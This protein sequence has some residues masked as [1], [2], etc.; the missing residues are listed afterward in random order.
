MLRKN[1]KKLKNAKPHNHMLN[2]KVVATQK[3]IY[4]IL[5]FQFYSFFFCFKADGM[6]THG[7]IGKYI[8]QQCLKGYELKKRRK[9]DGKNRIIKAR[10]NFLDFG[11]Y[12][13][14]L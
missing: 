12:I 14:F 10:W 6:Q 4:F 3:R 9:F 5:S 7:D 1:I 8:T 11:Y 13:F 2:D